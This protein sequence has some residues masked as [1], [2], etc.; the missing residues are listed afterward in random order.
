MWN[1]DHKPELQGHLTANDF[2]EGHVTI[3][4][5]DGEATCRFCCAFYREEGDFIV[6]YTEHAGYFVFFKDAEMEITGRYRPNENN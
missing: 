6:V 4:T 3:W 1:T 2:G 5:A